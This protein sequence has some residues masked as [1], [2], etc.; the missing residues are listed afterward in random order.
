MS[1]VEALP[2][3]SSTGPAVGKS[4]QSV[5][6]ERY[7]SPGQVEGTQNSRMIGRDRDEQSR[8]EE[9][10]GRRNYVFVEGTPGHGGADNDQDEA[11]V[12]EPN[13]YFFAMNNSGLARLQTL[14][15]FLD[16]GHT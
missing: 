14:L 9:Q 12:A 8:G 7:R 15:V 2:A 16:G 11:K 6:V 3:L 4:D 13:V 5:A 1:I 10:P